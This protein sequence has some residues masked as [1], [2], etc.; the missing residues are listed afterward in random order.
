MP[1]K[2]TWKTINGYG[3]YAYAQL[4]VRTGKHVTSKHVAYLGAYGSTG[5]YPLSVYKVPDKLDGKIDA[6]ALLIPSLHPAIKDDLNEKA[7]AKLKAIDSLQGAEPAKP[8][9]AKPGAIS[10]EFAESVLETSL[11]HVDQ[12]YMHSALTNAEKLKEYGY[13]ELAAQI[14]TAIVNAKKKP[15][16]PIGPKTKDEKALATVKALDV[17]DHGAAKSLEYGI[18]LVD[19]G[20]LEAAG[21]LAEKIAKVSSEGGPAVYA[22]FAK[23]L[24]DDISASQPKSNKAVQAGAAQGFKALDQGPTKTL[25]YVKVLIDGGYLVS[26]GIILEKMQAAEKL[27]LDKKQ[28]V[29][30]TLVTFTANALLKKAKNEKLVVGGQVH[31]TAPEVEV[32]VQEAV[33]SIDAEDTDKAKAIAQKLKDLGHTESAVYVLKAIKKAEDDGGELPRAEPKMTMAEAI[34]LGVEGLKQAETGDV[35]AATEAVAKLEAGGWTTTATEI[36]KAL[37]AGSLSKPDEP[38]GEAKDK[39]PSTGPK[40][41][42]TEEMALVEAGMKYANAGNVDAAK[43]VIAKV[44]AAGGTFSTEKIKKALEEHAKSLP[45]PPESKGEPSA[46]DSGLTGT[47]GAVQEGKLKVPKKGPAPEPGVAIAMKREVL[48]KDETD[49]D[50]STNLEYIDGQKGS[51]Y[52]GVYKD[53]VMGTV[54]YVKWPGDDRVKM[55]SVAS[56]LYRRAG[57]HTPTVRAGKFPQGEHQ[58]AVLSTWADGTSPMTKAQM[59]KSK[60]VRHG[61]LVDAWLANWDVVGLNSDNIIKASGGTALRVD[62]GGSLVYRAQGK[63]K[64]FSLA[65]DEY[66]S[67][68][69]AGANPQSAAVFKDM[70]AGE[71]QKA[72]EILS[73]ISEQQITDTVDD[74]RLPK[75]APDDVV[76]QNPELGIGKSFEGGYSDWLKGRLMGRRSRL[77]EKAAKEI[78][79]LKK[80]K[81]DEK[82][83]SIETPPVSIDPLALSGLSDESAAIVEKGLDSDLY[84]PTTY[85]KDKKYEARGEIIKHETG[86][87]DTKVKRLNTAVKVAYAENWKGDT[88]K[89]RSQVLR[90]AVSALD[91]KGSAELDR[92]DAFF[93]SKYATKHDPKFMEEVRKKSQTATGKS[94]KEGITSA[95]KINTAVV[96]KYNDDKLMVKVYRG[97]R[98]DQV[99]YMGLGDAQVGKK[100]MLKDLPALSW[101]LDP[102]KSFSGLKVVAEVPVDSIVVSDR[103]DGGGH[104]AE[105]DEVVFRADTL[106]ARV[107][108]IN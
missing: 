14:E 62:A 13:L 34:N 32:L 67:L 107:L 89:E 11:N 15:P 10:K 3:P 31:L 79:S 75:Q 97:F 56:E 18:S 52:G 74:A 8:P 25:E 50:W 86:G 48:K 40:M 69:S 93:K 73:S 30:W 98:Q 71:L 66:D 88:T 49:F 82:A 39:P 55:E 23:K 70:T 47:I 94:L 78:E 36:K 20:F 91:G 87:V 90:W 19:D 95:R 37:H 42:L 16:E 53:K 2:I 51:N 43:D 58:L 45:E 46:P 83:S 77:V 63:G 103:A 21:V 41:S 104:Y 24:K 100:I 5:I 92:M 28:K 44:E 17:A 57:V 72:S 65:P 22:K 29:S 80:Q 81:I 105:E 54:Y 27:D 33:D 4:S 76:E 38:A 35:E 59:A 101:S 96:G 106:D 12:G 64:K 108:G 68:R 26:A 99:A 6:N 60:D 9:A 7:A 61:F 84:R 85:N 102:S 1:P